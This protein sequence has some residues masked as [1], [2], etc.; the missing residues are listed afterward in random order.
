MNILLI[1]AGGMGRTHLMNYRVIPG[2]RV[3]AVVGVSEADKAAAGEWGLPI[4]GSVAEAAA[5]VRADLADICAPTYLHETLA[6]E[7]FRC[8]LHVITEKPCA[9]S[10]E[11]AGKMFS[12]ARKA[13]KNLYVAQVLR[14]APE[15]E[16]LY[17]VTREG[18]YGRPLDGVF[19]RLRQK[20]DWSYGS[21][22]LDEAK[23]GLLPYDLHI[24]DLDLIVSLFGP[25]ENVLV[26]AH[27]VNQGIRD[28]LRVEY[29]WQD[30]LTVSSEAAWFNA[31]LPFEAKWRVYYE[32][33][34]LVFDGKTVT[35]YG[36]N[37]HVT[38]F[39]ISDPVRVECG[40]GMPA[41]GWFFRELTHFLA[42]SAENRP[43]DV[44]TE[45]QVMTV[46]R[47]LETVSRHTRG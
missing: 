47:V 5:S 29:T 42:C 26:T 31:C 38:V 3:S 8:G 16:V 1:G 14:F 7:A 46:M 33:G 30:G 20:P 11:S 6:E 44:V 13:G 35:G 23:S 10:A 21:W 9:L 2:A 32:R 45:E 43:S 24:H 41:N 19:T 17:R 34:L 18:L 37:G 39:D 25:P 22:L 12:L 40:A 4:F 36:A 27:G 15:T 28:H